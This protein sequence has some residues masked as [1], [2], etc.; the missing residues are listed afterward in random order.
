MVQRSLLPARRLRGS[1]DVPGDKS[2]SHRAIL[3]NALAQGQARISN[4][5]SGADCLSSIACMQALGVDIRRQ[6]DEVQIT[7]AGRRRFQEPG[8]L[9]DC[10]NSGTTLRL[11]S[12]ILAARPFFS[13]LSGDASLRSRPQRRIVAPLRALGAQ[14]DGRQ[15]G[16]R[17]PLAI[18]GGNISGGRYDL[19]VASAQV[20]SALLLAALDAC[21]PLTLGGRIDTRDHTE[22]MLSTMGADLRLDAGQ[23]HMQPLEQD[24]APLSLRVPGDPSSAT[25][26]WVAAAIHPDAELTT[27]A[28]CFNPSR[29]G[30]IDVLQAMGAD[31][32]IENRRE[33]GG[34][35]VADVTVRSSQLRATS[36][37]GA[38]I[39]RLIDELPILALA[40]ACADGRT[41][42]RDAQELRTKESDRIASVA[43]GL[44]AMGVPV[45]PYADGLDIDGRPGAL[46]GAR[47]ESHHDH[48][49]TM[50]WAVAGLLAGGETTVTD[51]DAVG[52]SYP[53]F[54]EVLD[55]IAEQQ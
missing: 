28:V 16:D 40:A 55:Q 47:L 50:T 4:F 54:W 5:L 31:L 23:L 43:A 14:L 37:A 21:E 12:G 26:W 45:Q 1:I 17:A 6:G 30:A 22:R 34:E 52:V 19:T 38:I 24:L 8:D 35:P 42:I 44:T 49:L 39:P 36:I 48:R 10:G 11:L 15:D 51:A 41:S 9:L 33:E 7:S 18:R 53:L 25:F 20:K 2:I 13:I 27:T 29:S 46:R 32:R 3:F